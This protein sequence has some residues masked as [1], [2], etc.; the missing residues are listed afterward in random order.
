MNKVF[1][2]GGIVALLIIILFVQKMVD[3]YEKEAS[4]P[5][6]V[7]AEAKTQPTL[8]DA[9][10][11]K[12]EEP[13]KEAAPAAAIKPEVKP[14]VKPEPVVVNKPPEVK[15]PEV[16]VEAKPVVAVKPV[17]PKP[18]EV[19]K[20]EVKVEPKVE[21]KTETKPEVK[22]PP[23]IEAKI[24]TK[25]KA[26]TKNETLSADAKPQEVI[27]EAMDNVDVTY[28]IDGGAPQTTKLKADQVKV[29]KAKGKIQISVNDGGA[30]N[31]IHNGQDKG[32]PGDLGKPAQVKFP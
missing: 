24:E 11:I 7:T 2:V 19:K 4:V 8:E 27:L 10:T 30:V 16:K 17:E 28:Q 14:E 6:D 15:K 26:E 3:K 32:N 5:S 20:P 22:A 1:I 9:P 25:P 31:M 23:K 13:V 29:F 18:V 12:T 21:V